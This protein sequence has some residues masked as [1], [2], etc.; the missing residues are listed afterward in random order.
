MRIPLRSLFRSLFRTLPHRSAP[1]SLATPTAV[2]AFV[3]FAAVFLIATIATTIAFQSASQHML[4]QTSASAPKRELRGVWIASVSNIDFPLSRTDTP[5]KQRSDF[6][7]ILDAHRAM[8]INAVF[9]QVRPTADALYAKSREP[10]SFWLTGKQGRA[11]EPLW[12]PL[13]F[14]IT[15]AHKR[16]M[17]FHA[18]FNP[19][20]SVSAS[21]SDVADT[22][23]SK[24]RPDWHLTYS[25]PFRLLD[26]GN[27][28][29]RDYVTSVIM[30]VVRGYDID[31]VHFDDYFYPY[32][33]TTTQDAATFSRYP[34]GFTNI[35]DWRRD[36]VNLFVR[37]VYDSIRT[38]KPF[39]KF[40]I[41][42]FGIWKSNTPTGIV[43]LNA[44]D[45][46]YCD[47]VAWLQ[48]KSVDYI[49]PQL[50]W[51]FGGGQDY[52]KLMPWWL[53]QASQANRHLY[54]GLAAYRLSPTEAGG[55][56]AASDITPQVSANQRQGVHGS[57]FFNSTALTSGL[58]GL[59]TA[60][61]GGLFAT[62]AVPPTMAWKDSIAPRAPSGLTARVVFGGLDR[63]VLQWTKPLRASDGDT[64]R[65]YGIYRFFGAG[66][67]TPSATSS[68]LNIEAAS[69]LVGITAD[70]MFTD[71]VGTFGNTPSTRPTYVVTA[72]DRLWNE[73]PA[74]ARLLV[75][76]VN[77]TKSSQLSSQSSSLATGILHCSEPA[78]NPASGTVV[79]EFTLD[80]AAA[81][82]MVLFN[83][84]GSEVLRLPASAA[85]RTLPAGSHRQTFDT[86]TLPSG[87]YLCRV[88]AASSTETSIQTRTI[89]VER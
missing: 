61:A 41:S 82:S 5:D 57:V 20:R 80:H 32:A 87:V 89:V 85:Q 17:E 11:P 47:A 9:V 42:P 66:A 35:G 79:L 25:N 4:A 36:N 37:M 33:G 56:W 40:G 18:W 14:M 44:Y 24:T 63:V 69:A 62:I 54:A 21:T 27:P 70:T 31:G 76:S 29:V 46:I 22:H 45:V 28:E 78:P 88:A 74:T 10:W 8:G 72:F 7:R 65:Y 3:F 55:D 81:V 59:N 75:T 16:G 23:I 15:E 51:K 71:V 77:A 84:L 86:S 60:L 6:I 38:A 67:S 13:E 48:T 39:V 1:R 68:T 53:D 19:Y 52:A 34:R 83:A 12:D 26:P 49:L 30:D 2:S 50:Y 64:A 58:K 73:S 43:G